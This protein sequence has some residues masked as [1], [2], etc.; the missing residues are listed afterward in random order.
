M[1]L[2]QAGSLPHAGDARMQGYDLFM[3][4]ILAAA[5]LWGA[6]KGLAWQ[7]ASL[8]SIILSY[9]AA[10]SFRQPLANY[11]SQQVELVP[12]LD[13]G[14]AMLIL[15]IGTS[16]VVWVGFNLVSEGIEKV[17]L[18]E[19]DRQIGALL[20]LAKGVL[21]CTVITLL[22][23]T[24]VSDQ[25]RQQIYRSH[26]GYY[27]SVLLRKVQPILPPEIQS[28]I[29]PYEENLQKNVVP[30]P[31][32]FSGKFLDNQTEPTNQFQPAPIP[33][34]SSPA[35]WTTEADERRGV[36][37]SSYEQGNYAPDR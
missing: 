18:K 1:I 25:Q 9:I 26:S 32:E 20:G 22:A 30:R 35:N 13:T 3:I 7:V 16:I 34:E 17:K 11:L 10:L 31:S 24:I 14:L 21:L 23:V 5:I 8:A 15:F 28:R 12:P 36:Q 4:I 27:I 2:G 29:Q 6:W 33:R 19:F 37:R